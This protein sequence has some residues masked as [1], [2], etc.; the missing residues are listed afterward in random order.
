MLKKSD[1]KLK[2]RKFYGAAPAG[3]LHLT[4]ATKAG[5][6]DSHGKWL[7]GPTWQVTGGSNDKGWYRR[8]IHTSVSD[9]AVALEQK[10]NIF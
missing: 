6:V 7:D 3:S 8:M 9:L 2:L 5:R 10:S 4:G 1:T